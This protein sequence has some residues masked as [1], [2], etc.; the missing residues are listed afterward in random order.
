MRVV[1]RVVAAVAVALGL[2]GGGPLDAQVPVPGEVRQLVTFTFLPGR[3]ADALELYRSEALPLYRADEAMLSFR[4]FREVESP[5]PLDLVIVRGFQGMVGMD[6]SNEGLREIAAAAGSSIGGLYGRI[7]ALSSGHTDQFVEMLPD[8]GAGDPAAS[9]L[10]AFIWYRTAPGAGADFER[11][12]RRGVVSLEQTW[13]VPSSTGRFLVSDGW[14]YL[15][16]LGFESLGAFQ[17]YWTRMAASQVGRGLD[18]LT[19]ARRE[20]VLADLPDFRIR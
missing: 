20:A 14:D 9:R 13:G 12:L 1:A 6:A 15:R 8:L 11:R 2:A 5:V 18:E 16:I 4:A 19:A 7:S 10:T 17:D 3:S